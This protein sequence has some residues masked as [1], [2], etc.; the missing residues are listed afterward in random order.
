MTGYNDSGTVVSIPST[1]TVS[2]SDLPVTSI[3]A[4]AF[5]N[6]TKLASVTIPAS[7][8]SVGDDGLGAYP[9]TS[10]TVD[11]ANPVYSSLDGVF[12]D[13]AQTAL[14]QYP[15]SKAGS[16]YTIPGSVTRIGYD[17]FFY[18]LNLTSVTLPDSVTSI[19][20][21]AFDGLGTLTS[22]TVDPLNSVLSSSPDGV[23]FNKQQSTIVRCPKGKIGRYT[24]PNNVTNI[25]N[26]AF[27]FCSGL[28]NITV[29]S[30]LASIGNGAFQCCTGLSNV[31]IPSSLNCV[32]DYAF[33]GCSGLSSC[34]F[35]G[36]SPSTFGSFAFDPTVTVYYFH[37]SSGFTSPSWNGYSSVDIGAYS[38]AAP[39]LLSN[40]LTHHADLGSTPNHDGVPLLM[41]YALNLDPT[42][43][44]SAGV[45]QPVISGSQM[46]LT[47]YAGSEGVTYS[48]EASD[49]LQSWST[50]GVTVSA[51]DAN[52]FRTATVPLS[53]GKRFMRIKLA[54]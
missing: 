46:S 27:A 4:S 49:D 31:I 17:A 42:Q 29:P 9:M 28:T 14:L 15:E 38:P 50:L 32:G 10:I 7:V 20:D 40:G 37:G 54:Y 39:W 44:H 16:S 12:F 1:I 24:I 18:C 25:G 47:Y 13:K 52:Q 35:M 48:V 51:P 36:D 11:A 34:V 8:T 3:A 19:G 45:P 21:S 41:S 2:G 23:L 5:F 33:D 26:N 30:G 22:I 6:C 53:S 43:N